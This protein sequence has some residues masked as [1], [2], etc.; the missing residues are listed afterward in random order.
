MAL[1]TVGTLADAVRAALSDTGADD[2]AGVRRTD[3]GGARRP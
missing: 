1:V 3:D 2:R